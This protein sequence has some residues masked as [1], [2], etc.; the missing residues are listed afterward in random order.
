MEAIANLEQLEELLSRPTPAVTAM[1][2][3][4]KGDFMVLGSGGKIGPSLVRMIQ[5][6]NQEA[7]ATR[8]IIAVDRFEPPAGTQLDG[9]EYI[10]GDLLDEKF[11]KQLPDAP[12]IIY[13]AGM[14][15]GSSSSIALTWAMNAFL[16]AMV[17]RRFAATSRIAS[18]SSGNVY[19]LVPLASG[20]SIESDMPNP[21]G[22]YAMSCLGRDRAFEHYSEAAGLKVAII[23]L[24][25]ACEMRYG[26]LVDLAQ[27][28]WQEKSIDLSMGV[29]NVIWQGDANLMT[30]LSLEHASSPPFMINIAGPEQLSVRRVCEQFGELMGKKVSFTG[31]E[32][33]NALLNNGQKAHSMFGYPTVP[34]ATLMQWIAAWTR[35]GGQLLG[36]PTKFE[37]RDGKF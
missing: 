36:K 14:K 35:Q 5:R 7:G 2:K 18:F 17:A 32:S 16:P 29:A 21:L 8:R 3:R 25:Y 24:N 11:L 27:K 33:P 34:I 10:T 1:F 37:V 13:M 15:F 23:R 22:D 19:G 4:L 28:V 31:E 12:N 20:G 26:V 6:A 9:V 30:L